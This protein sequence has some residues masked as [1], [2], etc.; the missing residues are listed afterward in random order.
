MCEIGQLLI[1]GK[2]E[3]Q[4]WLLPSYPGT[5]KFPKELVKRLG[6]AAETKEVCCLFYLPVY[7][8]IDG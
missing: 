3:S 5:L 6:S 2:A 1:K 8:R 4:G 7:C